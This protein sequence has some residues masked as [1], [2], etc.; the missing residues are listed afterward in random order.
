MQC[1]RFTHLSNGWAHSN[2]CKAMDRYIR[3]PLT[4]ACLV[5]NLIVGR[6]PTHYAL[7][8]ILRVRSNCSQKARRKSPKDY[9]VR[10]HCLDAGA[11]FFLKYQ[12][13]PSQTPAERQNG[14]NQCLNGL[15][16]NGQQFTSAL[17]TAIWARVSC[18]RWIEGT[19][20]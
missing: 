6:L 14:C 4:V 17:S 5:S 10:R 9:W 3:S 18:R 16:E 12:G 8:Q 7:S 20:H 1:F 2:N 15:R 13:Q 19:A 11:T